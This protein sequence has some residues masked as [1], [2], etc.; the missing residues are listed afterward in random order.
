[1]A[2]VRRQGSASPR[3][4][5]ESI[6]E[7]PDLVR[8]VQALEPRAL[9]R[10]IDAVGLESAGELVALATTEQLERV[11]D[12]DLWASEIPGEDPRFDVR[13]FAVWLEVLLEGG[14]AAVAKRLAE[15]PEDLVTLAVVRS[16]LVLDLGEIGLELAEGLEDAE[17]IEKALDSG[18]YDEWEEFRLISRDA[19]VWEPLL[20]ALLALDRDHHAL[21]RRVLERA[22][23]QSLEFINGNGGLYEVL[24]SDEM[25]EADAHAARDDRR[26]AAGYVA[27]SDAKSFLALASQGLGHPSERDPVTR[28]YF[29]DFAPEHA[30]TEQAPIAAALANLRGRDST[31]YT[32][33]IE[34]LAYL[35]NVLIAAHSTRS[36][37]M[38]PSEA[39]AL[40][41][42]TIKHGLSTQ[43]DPLAG[44]TPLDILFRLGWRARTNEAPRLLNS[45]KRR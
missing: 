42:A 35:V 38:P 9:S 45:R 24:T 25:L 17:Q 32:Q 37:P 14:E 27:P 36:R 6:L 12:E 8:E 1:M 30:R 15:L 44:D 23:A 34:E 4:W 28:A 18:V 31:R 43:L 40:A 20:T 11:F 41:L 13:R 16:M 22:A 7:R 33:R 5:L 19:A 26:A 3:R 21:L 29:R 10:V 2:N 39:L